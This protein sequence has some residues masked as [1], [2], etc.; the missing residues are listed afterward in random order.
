M[1]FQ[2]VK[3]LF[4]VALL[5]ASG[6]ESS[7]ETVTAETTSDLAKISVKSIEPSNVIVESCNITFA[8]KQADPCVLSSAN[9]SYK[10]TVNTQ[11]LAEDEWLILSLTVLD[12]NSSSSLTLKGTNNISAI[13]GDIIT[14]KLRDIN[15]DGNVDLAMSTSFGV[16]NQYFDYWIND[17][18]KG[19]FKYIGNY[20]DF[21]VDNEKRTLKAT[22]KENAANYKN[23]EW[24]WLDDQLVVKKH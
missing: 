16:V 3:S 11:V 14:L 5:I 20:P 4:F 22:I 24:Q 18:V 15:F 8:Q 19:G 7:N 1:K 13:E 10:V 21:A 6:C 2:K 12:K 9:K 23:K 17:P